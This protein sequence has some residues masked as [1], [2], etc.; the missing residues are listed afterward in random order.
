MIEYFALTSFLAF[1]GLKVHSYVKKP[2]II[3]LSEI[4]I[5]GAEKLMQLDKPSIELDY[6]NQTNKE[7]ALNACTI[8]RDAL[9]KNELFTSSTSNIKEVEISYGKKLCIQEFHSSLFLIKINWDTAIR[10]NIHT[11]EITIE[12]GFNVFLKDMEKIFKG[13]ADYIEYENKKRLDIHQMAIENRHKL[14]V[15]KRLLNDKSEVI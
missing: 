3:Q 6:F 5:T 9:M 7:L 10:F 11:Q 14:N 15:M 12:E 4:E 8:I 2:K 1:T 13:V